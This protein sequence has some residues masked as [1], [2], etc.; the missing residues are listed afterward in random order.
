LQIQN[1]FLMFLHLKVLS[2]NVKELT[3]NEEKKR[4]D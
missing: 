3:L 1:A 2:E 4:K